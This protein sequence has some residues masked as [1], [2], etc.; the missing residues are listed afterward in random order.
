M[1]LS[2]ELRIF[3]AISILF[4]MFCVAATLV[5]ILQSMSSSFQAS[6]ALAAFAQYLTSYFVLLLMM[7]KVARKVRREINGKGAEF[8][9][10]ASTLLTRYSSVASKATLKSSRDVAGDVIGAPRGIV[11]AL[12]LEAIEQRCGRPACEL[13]DLVCG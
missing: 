12:I 9:T 4:S 11:S 1:V 3:P 8:V 2:N 5:L 10:R 6:F 13:F 7:R